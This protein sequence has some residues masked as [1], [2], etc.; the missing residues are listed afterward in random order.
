[1]NGLAV[2]HVSV[3]MTSDGGQGMGARYA[4]RVRDSH[5]CTFKSRQLLGVNRVGYLSSLLVL[6]AG[7]DMN[8]PTCGYGCLSMLPPFGGP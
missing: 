5:R 7:V 4:E 6:N 3:F 1:M 2:L 8:E